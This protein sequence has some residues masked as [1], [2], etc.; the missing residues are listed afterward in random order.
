[1]ILNKLVSKF[2]ENCDQRSLKREMLCN[3]INYKNQI[4]TK[5]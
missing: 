4:S 3:I 5:I 1:M 2:I